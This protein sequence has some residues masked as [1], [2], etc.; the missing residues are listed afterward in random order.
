MV[1]KSTLNLNSILIVSHLLRTFH[2]VCLKMI[3][4]RQCFL[5]RQEP[6]YFPSR[7]LGCFFGATERTSSWRDEKYSAL[8]AGW[9]NFWT[10]QCAGYYSKQ[11]R[12]GTPTFVV[13]AVFALAYLQQI[14]GKHVL[15]DSLTLHYSQG[16]KNFVEIAAYL[17]TWFAT[18]LKAVL[19]I[20]RNHALRT[21]ARI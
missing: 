13:L 4:V 11:I 7:G 3:N 18:V 10:D 19:F 14:L 9:S 2:S 8:V 1:K 21:L 20:H 15:F 12:T 5:F 6:N 16:T 17:H